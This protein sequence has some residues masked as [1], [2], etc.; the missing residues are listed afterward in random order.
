MLTV[1]SH[2]NGDTANVPD[3]GSAFAAYWDSAGSDTV[4]I[5]AWFN[6]ISDVVNGNGCS[7]TTGDNTGTGIHGCG[8][9]MAVTKG[10]TQA[11]ADAL[12][13]STWFQVSQNQLDATGNSF[14]TVNRSCNYDCTLYPPVI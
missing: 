2:Y 3:R 7:A 5:G 8:S 14:A 13:F 4:V 9:Y 11:E 12:F 10:A 1:S 6:A